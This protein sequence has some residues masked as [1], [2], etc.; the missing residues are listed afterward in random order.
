MRD[1]VIV[2]V[3]TIMGI[4]ITK[5][6]RNGNVNL[7]RRCFYGLS[8]PEWSRRFT[9]QE[10]VLPKLRCQAGAGMRQ[11]NIHSGTRGDIYDVT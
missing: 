4:V 10:A 2:D 6:I 9:L 1:P 3:I 11:I 7:G 5:I 8:M